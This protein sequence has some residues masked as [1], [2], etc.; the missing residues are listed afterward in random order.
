MWPIDSEEKGR[1]NWGKN[2]VRRM[3]GRKAVSRM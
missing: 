2:C 3:T 1:G